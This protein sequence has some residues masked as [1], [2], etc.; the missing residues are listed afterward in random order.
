M[1]DSLFV[2][3]ID[4]RSTKKPF[5]HIVFMSIQTGPVEKL[6]T[7]CRLT[8]DFGYLIDVPDDDIFKE[9]IGDW[10]WPKRWLE[11]NQPPCSAYQLVSTFCQWKIPIP[12]IHLDPRNLKPRHLRKMDLPGWLWELPSTVRPQNSTPCTKEP[13]LTNRY[14]TDNPQVIDINFLWFR[15]APTFLTNSEYLSA[16]GAKCYAH[17][18]ETSRVRLFIHRQE[19]VTDMM[20]I[21]GDINIAAEIGRDIR[22]LKDAGGVLSCVLLCCLR[23]SAEFLK[24]SAVKVEHVVSETKKTSFFQFR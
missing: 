10:R 1:F 12:D 11:G 3:G 6:T 2:V 24:K 8:S 5:A 23:H 16:G 15:H 22:D 13:I 14:Q 7:C 19:S 18:P 17:R 4:K 20:F 21:A 9:F